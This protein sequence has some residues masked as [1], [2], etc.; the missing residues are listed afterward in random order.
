MRQPEWLRGIN[1]MI[2]SPSGLEQQRET[3]VT[4]IQEWNRLHSRETS[5]VLIPYRWEDRVPAVLGQGRA[6]GVV[7]EKLLYHADVLIAIIHARLGTPT[8]AFSSGTEEEIEEALNRE[9]MVHVLFSREPVELED[10]DLAQLEAVRNY[11]RDLK[12]RNIGVVGEFHNRESLARQVRLALEDDVKALLTQ[13]RSA[14]ASI[15]DTT[16]FVQLDAG[17]RGE[18]RLMF[19]NRGD[20]PVSKFLIVSAADIDGLV[21]IEQAARPMDFPP[22][23]NPPIGYR[24]TNRT[25]PPQRLVVVAKWSANSRT[26]Q[27]HFEL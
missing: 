18:Y 23:T 26:R 8:G 3:I 1:V 27:T 2:G 13:Q 7:N 24:I 19:E 5:T 10:V 12:A 15:E 9:L 11:E 4:V 25:R 17:A 14:I 20:M 16:M 6:Q 21:D 22:H